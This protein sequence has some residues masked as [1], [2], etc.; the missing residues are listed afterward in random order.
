MG[1]NN[2]LVSGSRSENNKYLPIMEL[3]IHYRLQKKLF[4]EPFVSV[5]YP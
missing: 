4:T 1:P 5:G 2:S 3:N